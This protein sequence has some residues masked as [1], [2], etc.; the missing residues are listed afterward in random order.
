MGTVYLAHDPQ[1]ERRVALKMPKFGPEASE[2][3]RQRFVREA[4]AA[5]TLR[6]PNICPVYDV[7]EIAGQLYISMA[8]I[9][10]RS[11]AEELKTGR[12]FTPHEAASIVARLARR[13][14]RLTARRSF[15]ATSSPAMSCSM[16]KASPC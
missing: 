14:T 12:R 10:G 8:H 6:S 4:R 9:D 1:L 15:I 2:E 13:C 7:G 5:A 3:L 11:L 16:P